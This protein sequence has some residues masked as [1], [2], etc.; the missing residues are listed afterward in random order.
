MTEAAKAAAGERV[1]M[2]IIAS[3]QFEVAYTGEALL[4]GAVA[5]AWTAIDVAV[6]ERVRARLL[7]GA[8]GG[9]TGSG[10]GSA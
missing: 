8:T 6:D 7:A 3:T 10:S 4:D 5:M 9:G 1:E 2:P